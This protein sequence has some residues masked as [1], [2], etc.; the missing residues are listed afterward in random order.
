[1]LCGRDVGEIFS[2]VRCGRKDFRHEKIFKCGRRLPPIMPAGRLDTT[3]YTSL[4]LAV[5]PIAS[6]TG[7]SL[8]MAKIV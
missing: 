7:I 2:C 6:C 1:L 3:G 8:R 5:G 4:T